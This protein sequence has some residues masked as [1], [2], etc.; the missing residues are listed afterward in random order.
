MYIEIDGNIIK[1]DLIAS[2]SEPSES[3]VK[4]PLLH[5]NLL[6]GT[7]IIIHDPSMDVLESMYVWLVNALTM[8]KKYLT[9]YKG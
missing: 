1:T 6:G 9:T 8:E 3:I 4:Y 2:V 7:Q 5:I